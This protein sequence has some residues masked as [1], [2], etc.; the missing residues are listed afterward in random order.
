M[1]TKYVKASDTN[2]IND[3]LEKG[4]RL[5]RAY[6]SKDSDFPTLVFVKD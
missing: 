5:Y 4:F 6:R 2:R 3:L 1:K